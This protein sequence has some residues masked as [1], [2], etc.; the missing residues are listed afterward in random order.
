VA[1][2]WMAGKLIK[3][4]QTRASLSQNRLSGQNRRLGPPRKST[5]IM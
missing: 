4:E 3:D 1:Q 5:I 2:F